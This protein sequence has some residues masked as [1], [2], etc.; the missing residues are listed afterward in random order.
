VLRRLTLRSATRTAQRA[1]LSLLAG[2]TNLQKPS[3]IHIAR[4]NLS[5]V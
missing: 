4:E 5:F 3:V 2:G 1:I